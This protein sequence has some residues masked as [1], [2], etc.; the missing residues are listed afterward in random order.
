LSVASP[1]SSFILSCLGVRCGKTEAVSTD[2]GGPHVLVGGRSR[3]DVGGQARDA[4]RKAAARA[5]ERG[6]ASGH[7]DTSHGLQYKMMCGFVTTG[8]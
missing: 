1:S 6:L 7:P 2:A 3:R 4:R 5:S 8:S